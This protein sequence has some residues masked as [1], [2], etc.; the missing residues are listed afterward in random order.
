M[1]RR[2]VTYL[3]PQTETEQ[4]RLVAEGDYDKEIIGAVIQKFYGIFY[5]SFSLNQTDS[6]N[7]YFVKNFQMT[8][9]ITSM[10]GPSNSLI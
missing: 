1:L 9:T 3:D 8:S 4:E 2:D 6:Q 10:I 5:N 7:W